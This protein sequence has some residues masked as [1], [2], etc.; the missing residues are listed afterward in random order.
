MNNYILTLRFLESGC[1]WCQESERIDHANALALARD[2][3]RLTSHE[4]I[5]AHLRRKRERY[6][7]AVGR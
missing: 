4:N 3:M 5:T 1:V 6:K 2:H 7:K